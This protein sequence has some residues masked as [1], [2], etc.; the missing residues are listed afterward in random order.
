VLLQESLGLPVFQYFSYD[1][2]K[3]ILDANSNGVKNR[4]RHNDSPR[5][6]SLIEV[7]E[8]NATILG[9]GFDNNGNLCAGLKNE[10]NRFKRVFTIFGQSIFEK[11]FGTFAEPIVQ[12]GACCGAV[13]ISGNTVP[14]VFVGGALVLPVVQIISPPPEEDDGLGGGNVFEC[15]DDSSK[16][17]DGT[18]LCCPYTIQDFLNTGRGTLAHHIRLSDTPGEFKSDLR[19][20]PTTPESTCCKEIRFA[21]EVVFT[22]NGFGGS[23][24]KWTDPAGK[25]HWNGERISDSVSEE[26]ARA[27]SVNR[28]IRNEVTNEPVPVHALAEPWFP[29]QVP[30]TPGMKDAWMHDQPSSAGYGYYETWDFESCAIC[31]D[32]I[33]DSPLD[34]PMGILNCVRFT[35]SAFPDGHRQIGPI[36]VGAPSIAFEDDWIE[37]SGNEDVY[38]SHGVDAGLGRAFARFLEQPKGS[39]TGSSGVARG[40]QKGIQRVVK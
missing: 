5:P 20:V 38:G 26:Y 11:A 37:R 13:M 3:L 8:N 35:L 6:C 14:T 7:N 24:R 17:P 28:V 39:Q 12:T 31:V 21:Q 9:L 34:L 18:A 29:L 22:F 40:V 2:R 10:A 1:G 33:K 25:A 27:W 32:A 16:T 19:Y 36:V 4:Y 30:W 23:W 15:Q